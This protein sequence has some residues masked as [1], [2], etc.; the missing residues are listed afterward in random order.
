MVLNVL[1]PKKV[2]VVEGRFPKDHTVEDHDDGDAEVPASAGNPMRPA[3]RQ[4]VLESLAHALAKPGS[5]PTAPKRR[6]LTTSPNSCAPE[7]QKPGN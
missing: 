2:V 5:A 4:I 1:V 3:Q 7:K 6:P